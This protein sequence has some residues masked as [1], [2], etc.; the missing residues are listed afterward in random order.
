MKELTK[1]FFFIFQYDGGNADKISSMVSYGDDNNGKA[2]YIEIRGDVVC[3]GLKTL[4]NSVVEICTEEK[5]NNILDI[6]HFKAATSCLV[7]MAGCR[8][9]SPERIVFV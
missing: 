1:S 6:K 5:V 4:G 9:T 2:I 7:R 8:P 3:A